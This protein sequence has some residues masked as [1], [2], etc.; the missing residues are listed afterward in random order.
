MRIMLSYQSWDKGCEDEKKG[1][2]QSESFLWN[3]Y[4]WVPYSPFW[5]GLNLAAWQPIFGMSR[6]HHDYVI[7]KN[8][9]QSDMKIGL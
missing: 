1:S 6:L 2:D 8:S 9:T 3:V 4:Y 7:T 5:F